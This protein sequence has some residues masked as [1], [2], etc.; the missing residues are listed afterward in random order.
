MKLSRLLKQVE[1]RPWIASLLAVLGGLIYLILS[2]V[3]A[4]TQ[5]SILDEGAYLLK[6]YLFAIGKYRPFQDY[7]PWTNHMP[8]SYLI[9]GWVQVV[10]GTGLRTGRYLAVA[11]GL[12][13]L[14]GLWLIA[15]RLGNRWWATALIWLIALNA[16]VL[17]VYSVMTSQVL[18][19]C[20]LVW[21]LVFIL[22][23]DR[24]KWQIHMGVILAG[25]LMLTRINM[26][27]VLPLVLAYVFWEHGII[28]G[29][30]ATLT[31]MLAIGLGHAL[32]WP[33]I[34]KIWAIWSPID[35]PFLEFWKFPPAPKPLWS[36]NVSLNGRLLSFLLNLRIHFTP[37]VG[38]LMT[39]LMWPPKRVWRLAWRY[40]AAVFLW[41]SFIFLFAI[42]AW[43]SLGK[44]YCVYCLPNYLMFF[45][46]LGFLF[47]CV[48][49][50]SWD[51]MKVLY[52]SWLSIPLMVVISTGIG[53][54]GIIG[55]QITGTWIGG[56]LAE[57]VDLFWNIQVPRIRE[58]HIIP[59]SGP[60]W[61]ILS[62][63]F[64]WVEKDIID[65][66]LLLVL[67]LLGWIVLFLLRKWFEK[68]IR[69]LTR[70]N[71]SSSAILVIVF[72]MI[73]TALNL[74]IGFVPQESDCDCG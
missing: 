45:Q 73:G 62:N 8:F 5:T 33:E 48:A 30:W 2:L 59:G 11:L 3:Y 70:M 13:M 64:G 46:L 4:H 54:S 24:P 74:R 58:M 41:V 66:T 1:K 6:G 36:P 39:T 69:P 40:R 55:K 57:L 53:Y 60:L 34:L 61:G 7:G 44:S 16:P 51:S 26:S 72:L 37:I 50:N 22:G 56:R 65:G 21:M 25:I 43:A 27:P 32:F 28:T 71:V 18:V 20:I 19:S 47:I 52:K 23:P 14:V 12:G 31:G 35:F 15:N 9:P 38:L 49:L 68:H 67:L 29:L 17:R 10:F 63:K 42:H